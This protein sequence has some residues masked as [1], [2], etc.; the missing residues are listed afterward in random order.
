MIILKDA[1]ICHIHDNIIDLATE[2]S[3]DIHEYNIGNLDLD[4]FVNQIEYTI[5]KIMTRTCTAKYLAQ[6]MEDR[7]KLYKETIESLGFERKK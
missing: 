2:L 4:E 5:N 7:L 1:I 6:R 3:L